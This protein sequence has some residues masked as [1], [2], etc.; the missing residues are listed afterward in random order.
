MS[1]LSFLLFFFCL[2]SLAAAQEDADFLSLGGDLYGGGSVVLAVGPSAHDVFLAGQDTRLA[3]PITGSAHLVGQTVT[4]DQ[5][6][7]GNAYAARQTVTLNG[8]VGGSATLAGQMVKIGDIGQNLRAFGQSVTTNGIVEG[9][10]LITAQSVSFNGAINGDVAVNANTIDFG[11]AA[12]VGG[13]LTI[14][15][16][17]PASIDVPNSVVPAE[18]I[19]RKTIEQWSEDAPTS[20]GVSGDTIW[21]GVLSTVVTITI[22]AAILAALTPN[23]LSQMR[24]IF[25]ARPFHSFWLGFLTLSAAIGTTVV[26]AMTLIGLLATPMSILLAIVLGFAGYIVGAYALGV[27]L[28]GLIGRDAP[29]AWIER[30][31]AAAVGAVVIAAVGIVPFIGWLV[32]LAVSITG[33]GALCIVFFSP[34]FFSKATPSV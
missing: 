6:I 14:Y 20:V 1:K 12:R 10:A 11:S 24:T 8:S 3:I 22:L 21:R 17:D 19:I 23:K 32:I 29:G 28:L 30:A 25:L 33:L 27:G 7:A 2:P 15:H 16:S 9:A 13:T 4:F 26:F 31:L 5:P 34:S 18:R